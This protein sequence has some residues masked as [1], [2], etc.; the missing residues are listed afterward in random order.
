MD[1]IEF[2]EQVYEENAEVE[3]ICDAHNLGYDTS[4]MNDLPSEFSEDL[5]ALL[6]DEKGA[7][8][9][10]FHGTE[11]MLS[12]GLIWRENA[13]FTDEFQLDFAGEDGYIVVAQVPVE[14]IKWYIDGENEF[15]I[16]AGK[17]DCEVFT[18][19]EYFGL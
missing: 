6:A 1:Y 19:K 15:I 10:L 2:T 7:V 3:A 5:Q 11:T 17:L 13:S 16:T 18:V 12:N 8:I 9:E 14:R 4:V